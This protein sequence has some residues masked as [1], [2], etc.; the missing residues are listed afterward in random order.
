MTETP[1]PQSA[2]VPQEVRESQLSTIL[3]LYLIL[4]LTIIFFYTQQGLFNAYTDYHYYYRTAQ[5]SEQGYYPFVN[6]WYEYPPLLAYLPQLAY[7]LTAQILPM[8]E[9]G[10]LSFQV[11]VRVLAVLV[12]F[13]DAGVL[14]LVHAIGRLVWGAQ[15]ADW[16]AWVYSGL[17]LPLFWLTFVHQIVPVFFLLLGIYLFLRARPQGAALAVG[18]GVAAKVLPGLLLAPLVRFLWPQRGTILRVIVIA[19]LVVGLSYLPFFLLGGGRWVL[20]SWQALAGGGSYG[21]VWA[22]LDGNWG[23]GTYG[24]LLE[25][26]DLAAAGQ[27]HAN[28]ARL[29]GWLTL[30]G[31][32]L[33]YGALF[34]R[35]VQAENPRHFIWFSTLTALIFH[36][37][38]RGW[39]PHWALTLTPLFLLSSPDRTGLRWTLLL[40]AIIFLEWPLSSV[41]NLRPIMA[42]FILLRT[43]LLI[44]VAIW[45][46]RQLWPGQAVA[47]PPS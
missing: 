45:T 18:L 39:S 15:K 43:A 30:L 20:A 46:A 34:I 13:F 26:L 42:L 8:G 32:G 1:S 2:A 7:W 16:L 3:A 5:L 35:P 28:P 33:L 4:R 17:S 47:Q 27:A 11:F 12:L 9:L 31:F 21:T 25:R 24:G 41:L 19:V 22:I 38:L 29:P 40:T 14:L 44:W 23:P 10:S 6:M 37:W 36:L